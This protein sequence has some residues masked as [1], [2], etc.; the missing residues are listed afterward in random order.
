MYRRRYRKSNTRRKFRKIFRRTRKYSTKYRKP[1]RYR[2]TKVSIPNRIISDLTF[3]KLK[4]SLVYITPQGTT[5]LVDEVSYINFYV[6]GS[7]IYDWA[8]SLGPPYNDTQPTGFNEWMQF[9]GRFIVHKSSIRVTPLFWNNTSGGTT[10][11]FQITVT[12]VTVTTLSS[13]TLQFDEQPYARFK[14][15][16]AVLPLR[17]ATTGSITAANTGSQQP[18]FVYNSMMTKKMLGVKDLVDE[19]D[20]QGTVNNS[21]DT[22]FYWNIEIKSLAP[23]GA[24]TIPFMMPMGLKIDTY[25]K[26]QFLDRLN[27]QQSVIDD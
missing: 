1:N 25:Y 10:P 17:S 2:R 22:Q 15:N 16:N 7:D 9:Y 5:P 27:I 4:D 19:P 18:M 3:V 13:A 12:P 6:S 8:L 24:S 23:A 26:V 20:V 11:P 21:P 14:I